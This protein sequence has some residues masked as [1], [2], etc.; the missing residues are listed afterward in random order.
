RALHKEP[1][2][3][4]RTAAEMGRDL[5]DFIAQTEL[6]LD[7]V[8]V[9]AKKATRT[10]EPPLRPSLVF[11]NSRRTEA[12]AQSPLWWSTKGRHKAWRWGAS[13]VL[14]LLLAAAVPLFDGSLESTGATRQPDSPRL[15]GTV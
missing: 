14:V 10:A 13:V 2:L 8:S 11:P 4:Y 5:D 6:R 7:E 1:E 9:L 3:R 12:L 15:H